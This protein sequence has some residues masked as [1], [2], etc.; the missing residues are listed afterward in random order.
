MTIRDGEA[1]AIIDDILIAGDTTFESG[2]FQSGAPLPE[3]FTVTVTD[4]STGAYAA[5]NGAIK[6]D[7]LPGNYLEELVRLADFAYR[8]TTADAEDRGWSPIKL[9]NFPQ[10]IDVRNPTSLSFRSVAHAYI[11]EIDGKSTAAFAFRGTDP[12]WTTCPLISNSQRK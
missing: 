11:G 8:D 7:D 2:T 6:N 4:P 1:N 12:T 9:P 10:G 5:A 3:N